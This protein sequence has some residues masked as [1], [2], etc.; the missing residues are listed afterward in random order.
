MSCTGFSPFNNLIGYLH[1]YILDAI[2]KNKLYGQEKAEEALNS[3]LALGRADG[4]ILP[5]AD[6]GQYIDHMLST[7]TSRGKKMP[8]WKVY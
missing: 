7:I 4:L 8:I 1:A 3:A 5:F 2:V 6:Y